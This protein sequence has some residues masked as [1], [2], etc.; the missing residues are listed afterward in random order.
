MMPRSGAPLCEIPEH[1]RA[2]M[3]IMCKFSKFRQSQDATEQIDA[4]PIKDPAAQGFIFAND[5]RREVRRH[6]VRIDELLVERAK[7]GIAEVV[8]AIE[9]VDRVV[10]RHVP[11][12]PVEEAVCRPVRIR[13]QLLPGRDG[14]LRI[15]AKL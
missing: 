10:E 12:M 5:P 7:P 2:V 4:L 11:T 9:A 3:G 14:S 15:E 8:D 6:P 1:G 13:P